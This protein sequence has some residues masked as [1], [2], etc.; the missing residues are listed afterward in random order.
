MLTRVKIFFSTFCL[1]FV[2]EVGD[3]T[4]F[5]IIGLAAKMQ[6]P[7]ATLLGAALGFV[8][9]DAIGVYLSERMSRIISIKNVKRIAGIVFIS[10]G[11]L[12]LLGFI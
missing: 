10:V 1:L 8:I 2:A 6:A 7:L 9:V 4:Q 11:A 5:A 12:T 3:K